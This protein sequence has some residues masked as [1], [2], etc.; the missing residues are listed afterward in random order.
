M[1]LVLFT[2]S[3]GSGGAQRQL[4]LL[5]S[6]FQKLGHTAT[7]LTYNSGLRGDGEFFGPW[8]ESRGIEHKRLRL[9]PRW[10][11]PLE[12]RRT[13]KE[14]E[15]DAVL[16]FQEAASLY[17]ELAGLAGRRWGLVVSERI[18]DPGSGHGWRRAMRLGH[19]VADHVTAN[20]VANKALIEA[21][22]GCHRL[23]VHVIYNAVDLSHFVPDPAR[24]EPLGASE[25][26]L[27]L[28]V[29]AS[30]QWKKN[31]QNVLAAFLRLRGRVPV[32]LRW[33]GGTGSDLAPLREAHEFVRANALEG[34]VEL[35]PPTKD[36]RQAYW[37]SDAV[38]L[39]SWYEGCPNVI[40]EAMACG[41]PVLSSAV[42]DNPLIVQDG[43]T[44]LLFDPH[45]PDAI[46]DAI[47]RFAALDLERRQAMGAAG[48]RR[49]ES[50]FAPVV[51]ARRYEELL[52]D[53][54]SRH[55]NAGRPMR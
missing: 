40:C 20:S 30:H 2:D 1:N 48:R 16:A 42:S 24:H 13:L 4:C 6:E 44:G 39:A 11:R 50:L 45:S 49:A 52:E 32:H 21:P 22:L 15:P 55:K 26:P 17:A 7:V 12:L 34:M 35:L 41:K 8:L 19:R 43:V 9:V 27:Q 14:L 46:A 3:L 33:Y 54:A 53:A 5:A 10:Q 51:C 37:D 18:A 47:S 25:R 28:V 31:L 29:L 38:M 36:P 23:Q